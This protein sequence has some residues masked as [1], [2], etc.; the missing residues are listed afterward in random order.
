MGTAFTLV[1]LI[2]HSVSYLRSLIAIHFGCDASL[3]R[4]SGFF[5]HLMSLPTSFF[6]SR[7]VGDIS[8][9]FTSMEAI[10]QTLL[11][12]VGTFVVDGLVAVVSL[13]VLLIYNPS[14]ALVSLLSLST[15][16]LLRL[17]TL[18]HLRE[19]SSDQIERSARVHSHFIESIRGARV[20]QM[21]G[22]QR[23][24]SLAWH[25]LLVAQ[26]NS[27]YR[28]MRLRTNAGQVCALIAGMEGVV[29]LCCSANAV[30]SGAWT[31]GAMMAF[32]SYRST[33]SV[34]VN[35]IFDKILELAMLR[36]HFD[37][38][39]DISETECDVAVTDESVATELGMADG[40]RISGVTFRYAHGEPTLLS[41]VS[42]TILEGECVALIGGS[43][44][45]K[46]TLVK[47]LLGLLEPVR[48]D[49]SVGGRSGYVLRSLTNSGVIAAVMQDDTLFGGTI[50]EN[51]HCF[52]SEPDLSFVRSC[53]IAARIHDDIMELPMGYMTLV[54]DMGSSLSGGQKQRVIL[55]R[56]L[57]RRPKLL[58]LDEAT[59]H[60]D[61]GNEALISS[62]IRELNITRLIVAHRPDTIA[63]ADRIVELRGGQLHEHEQVRAPALVTPL[64]FAAY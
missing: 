16:I 43:G 55:A 31:L 38:L 42:L 61:V 13:S 8:S 62:A 48:G 3:K 20:I 33:F 47:L 49:V 36:L 40:V 7:S 58:I 4:K 50:E 17:I 10:H 60:L 23:D 18:P 28:S 52:D 11:S 35:A 5:R 27:L 39:A 56:A 12:A 57:Y 19:V 45:G 63:S 25:N 14:I 2:Q 32:S 21:F 24:R 9:R 64:V 46:T 54:G 6:E 59:S 29:V 51:I 37:R 1:L 53:A 44:S 30:I 41:N 15:I 34:R 26:Y 22:R